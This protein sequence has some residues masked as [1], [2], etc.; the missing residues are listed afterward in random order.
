LRITLLIILLAV[1]LPLI[2]GY[3]QQQYYTVTVTDTIPVNPDNKYFLRNPG[4][5][6][7]SE[8]LIIRD[9]LLT[10]SD[11]EITYSRAEI[12]LSDTLPYSIFDTL[13]ITYDILDVG[14]QKEYKKRSLVYKFDETTGDTIRVLQPER[15][16]FT[17]DAIFGSNMEK[18]G[19]LIRGFTVGT[20]K[21]FT[22]S[23]GLRL[24]V[25]GNLSEDIELV[26]ALT[27][28]NT[29]I[30]PEGNTERLEELDKVFIQ[31]KHPLASGI[32][33]DYQ[34][35]RRTGEFGFVDRKLQ[36]LTGEFMYEGYNAFV[37][38]AGSKGKFNTNNFRGI[39]GVQGPYR[40]SGINSERDIIIIAGTEEVYIDGIQMKRGEA[41]D[42]VIEY[43]NAQITFTPKRLITSASRI[44]VDFEYTDRRYQRNFFG[45]GTGAKMLNDKLSF[46]MQYLQEGDD[47]KS[48]IDITLTD[49][50]REI[51][52][53]AGDN[54]LQA[55]R[56]GVSLAPPDTSGIVRGTY[57]RVD[58][59]INGVDYTFYV[60]NPG[61]ESALYNL[62][63]SFVG[64]GQGDYARQ[65][66]G[67]FRFAGI[68]QGSYMPVVFIPLPELKQVGNAVITYSPDKDIN[69]SFEYAGSLLDRNRLS[70][71]NEG[72]NF[73]SARNISLKVNPKDIGI[74]KLSLGKAGISYKDRYV[75]ERF[76]S[77]D[78][79]NQIEFNRIYNTG[80]ASGSEQLRELNL[81]FI[82]IQEV[83]INTMYGF[84]SRGDNFR[85]DRF[86]NT[87]QVGSGK[88]YSVNYNLDYV[89]TENL[90]FSS[91][92]VRQK[93]DASY[94]FWKL[95]PGVEYLGEDKKDKTGE[96]DSLLTGS[97]KYD[98]LTPFLEVLDIEGIKLTTRLSFRDEYLPLNGVMYKESWAATQS[99]ELNYSGIREV[100]TTL[101][102][103]FRERKYT[104]IFKRRGLLNSETVL[105]RSQSR[106]NL[107]EPL[108]GDLFYEVST[109]RS[110]RLERVFI[111]VERGLGNYIYAGDL[112]N[113]GVADENEYQPVLFDGDYI[114]ITI[115]S[116]ELYPVIDLKTSTR[117]KINFGDIFDDASFTSGLLNPFSAE[118]FWRIEENST[119]QDYSR[120][121]LLN[122]SSLLNEN[123]TIRGSN[124]I[125]QDFFIFEND[126]ELSFRLRYSQR[127]SLNQFSGGMEKGYNRE[128]SL[129][130]NFKLIEEVS[131]QT[132]IVNTSDNV[133]APVISN[134][135][136]EINSNGVT[137][138]FSYRPQRSIEV[139]FKL[140]AA[141]SEDIYPERPTVVDI[142]S[143][144]L[145]FNLSFAGTGRLRVEIERNEL[146]ANNTTENF[147]PFELL[148]VILSARIISGGLTLI[149]EYQ[150]TFSQI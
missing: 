118:T 78:R 35:T 40:L 70:S 64:E 148:M 112:N 17:P 69:L 139:G 95:R 63:F 54:R 15:G 48:P 96:K 135:K 42:Y 123:T 55:V 19:T 51:L 101:N 67:H 120:I 22:L 104:D 11:Y 99:Y 86:N 130:I 82:P 26:A 113:N 93:G 108:R 13:F 21:D 132:D 25:A 30:Q 84:L 59:L 91:Y 7:Y 121:Y 31:I 147:I 105:V 5:I 133:A 114:V 131:N 115:P 41:N 1:S 2:S 102:L 142:N 98:E 74:G 8:K 145:R 146:L 66:L 136:R 79:I 87:I 16:G 141:K 111:P 9:S 138:D 100:N 45:A 76:T 119:E 57:Q 71:L 37:S 97:L 103:V 106:F 90:N 128:R 110:A 129:R 109:Q 77:A 62:S 83:Y 68:N 10:L 125:Q 61:S 29:P 81:T 134:R 32:F 24:Q 107:W 143:I 43:G 49:E 60:Y 23:S 28:E 94:R 149:T 36:G 124:F 53:N 3:A 18:S 20:T 46:Q 56:S 72:D 150:Q 6:P 52:S 44:T 14:F 73:G 122:F 89:E 27:D 50:D 80:T 58:T 126:P 116:D 144:A 117:W 4:I 47:P 12:S 75:E 38:L 33:G 92:W 65:S 140:R 137:T 39:E 85:S 34:M 88:D 127:K